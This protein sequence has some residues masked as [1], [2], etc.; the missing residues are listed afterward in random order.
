MN[1]Q[2]ELPRIELSDNLSLPNRIT[3]IQQQ[4]L[5]CSLDLIAYRYLFVRV[6]STNSLYGP[7][8]FAGLDFRCVNGHRSRRTC[9]LRVLCSLG[10]RGRASWKKHQETKQQHR[11]FHECS[12]SNYFF[13]IPFK[14]MDTKVWTTSS[15]S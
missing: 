10:I 5:D 7:L 12:S 9:G 11:L 14:K 6:E 15:R 8:Q 4:L 13:A 3:K 2:L 1:V